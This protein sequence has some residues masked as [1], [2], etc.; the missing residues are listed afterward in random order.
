MVKYV[1]LQ[2]HLVNKKKKNLEK[3]TLSKSI[4]MIS[5]YCAPL[6]AESICLYESAKFAI[7]I[8]KNIKI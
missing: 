8:M 6:S 2:L 7:S 3:L 4:S 1:W 5:S